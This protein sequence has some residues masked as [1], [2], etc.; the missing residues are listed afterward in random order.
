MDWWQAVVS[1][2]GILKHCMGW[3]NPR[4]CGSGEIQVVKQP[5]HSAEPLVSGGGSWQAWGQAHPE[6]APVCHFRDS[7]SREVSWIQ[8]HMAV[9]CRH[10]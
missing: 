6:T 5:V 8:C 3:R 7:C 4:W 10:R 9:S 1:G 2:G